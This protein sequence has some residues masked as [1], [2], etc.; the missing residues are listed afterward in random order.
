M[1]AGSAQ[2]VLLVLLAVA[3]LGVT[4]LVTFIAVR[5]PP[6]PVLIGGS[7]KLD[8]RLAV[9]DFTLTDQHGEPYGT[10]QLAGNVW[11]VDFIFTRCPG[12]CPRMST[13]MADLQA[14]LQNHP[15]RQDIHLVSISVDPGHD[16]PA[17]LTEYA[18]RYTADPQ[19]W[20]FLTGDREAIWRLVGQGFRETVFDNIDNPAMP[21]GHSANFILVDRRQNIRGYFPGI[22]MQLPD[23]TIDP[24][25]RELLLERLEAVLNE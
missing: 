24:H 2:R 7:Q 14:R 20:H 12:T 16:T 18:A 4:A 23:G 22:D 1:M 6:Q 17:V 15:R 13:G 19:Q 3:T 10:Q 25:E 11:I 9:P 5:R 21:I 8:P